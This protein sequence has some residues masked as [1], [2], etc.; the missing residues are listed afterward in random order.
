MK[1]VDA[2]LV[3][4][5]VVA[6]STVSILSLFEEAAID[7]YGVLFIVEFFIV[8]ELAPPFPPKLQR[9]RT[10]IA[11]VLIVIF[12]GILTRRILEILL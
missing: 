9:R 10:L 8:S 1:N 11:M 6:F 4:Y 3:I 5:S 12:T 7:V 2:F